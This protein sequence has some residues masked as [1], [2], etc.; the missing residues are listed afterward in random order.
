MK[1]EITNILA[2][3][4]KIG[5]YA[6]AAFGILLFVVGTYNTVTLN[7]VSYMNDNEI[8]FVKRLDE[9]TDKVMAVKESINM[10]FL[11]KYAARPAKKIAK[12]KVVAKKRVAK[13]IAPIK[14]KRFAAVITQDLELDLVEVFNSK[15]FKAGLS[16]ADFSGKVFASNGVIESLEVSLP[17]NQSIEVGYT[18]MAGNVFKYEVDGQ[19]YSGMMYEVKKG[20]YMVTLANGPYQGTRMKFQ[21]Y[22]EESN[23]DDTDRN[24]ANNQDQYVDEY[25][26]QF[27]NEGANLGNSDNYANE[28]K[29]EKVEMDNGSQGYGYNFDSKSG[30]NVQ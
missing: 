25:D 19:S 3:S 6:T 13:A 24:V 8:K 5:M 22:V 4:K 16:S 29:V 15:L 1:F 26:K 21:G 11:N 18:E 10:N 30:N 17:N 23:Y 12:K 20:Q 27:V 14:S 28:K 2:K 9:I 7:A